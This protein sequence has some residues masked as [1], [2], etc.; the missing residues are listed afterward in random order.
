MKRALITVLALLVVGSV[1]AQSPE[2][3]KI[4]ITTWNLEW[5]PDGSP[6]EAA[7]ENQAQRVD[8][9]A[10]LHSAPLRLST[11]GPL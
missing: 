2:P 8:A 10:Q 9:A 5:F 6:R 4:R 7:L 11:L 1:L 3:A